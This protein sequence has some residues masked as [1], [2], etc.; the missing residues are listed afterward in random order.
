M[1]ANSPITPVPAK[2]QGFSKKEKSKGQ[3]T[4]DGTIISVRKK[5][6]EVE[7]RLADDESVVT[8]TILGKFVASSVAIGLLGLATQGNV[9]PICLSC[10][11]RFINSRFC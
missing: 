11:Y 10:P 6:K 9:P 8:K 1:D 4:L 2:V 3:S 7:D 5:M